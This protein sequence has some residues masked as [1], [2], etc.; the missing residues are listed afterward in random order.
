L[1]AWGK[2]QQ[3]AQ[4]QVQQSESEPAG[5]QHQ[6]SEQQGKEEAQDKPS[7]NLLEPTYRTPTPRFLSLD[8]PLV[9]VFSVLALLVAVTA[10]TTGRLHV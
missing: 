8:N 9:F 6:G 7:S 4:Q 1:N 5:S 2:Q 3:D 10:V